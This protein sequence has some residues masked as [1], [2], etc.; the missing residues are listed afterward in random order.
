MDATR[1]ASASYPRPS[2]SVRTADSW[3][4]QLAYE[5]DKLNELRRQVVAQE[6]RFSVM[7]QQFQRQSNDTA[8]WNYF[9]VDYRQHCA[10]RKPA[11][12]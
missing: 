1:S 3:Q 7:Q 9:S 5:M 10:K 11:G 2:S 6:E 12:I 4:Y 8:G